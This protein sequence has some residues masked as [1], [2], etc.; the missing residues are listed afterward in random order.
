LSGADSPNLIQPDGVLHG[1]AIGANEELVV[2]N[3]QPLEAN[4][5]VIALR[6]TESMNLSADGSL[7]LVFD[8]AT[9][10][11]TISF[12]EDM[13]IE[14]NGTLRL[15]FASDVDVSSQVGRTFQVFDWNGVSPSGQ[16]LLESSLPWDLSSLYTD[17][18]VTLQLLG[19]TDGDLRVDL[20]DLNNVRNNF[21]LSGIDVLGDTNN[22]HV[23]DL[24]DLN[25]V[26]NNF[27][28]SAPIPVPEPP[29]LGLLALGVVGFVFR[30][31]KR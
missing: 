29:S 11:S 6:I 23:V 1:L 27:G 8:S 31:S 26:R 15:G 13:P 4:G 14:L 28:A 20:S 12:D 3:Y 5:E 2:R 24:T 18:N 7:S 10:N 9:W 19:D 16:F 21:G 25:N 30:R 17:G 22:D